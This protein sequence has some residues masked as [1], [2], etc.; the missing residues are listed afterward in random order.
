MRQAPLASIA[1]LVGMTACIPEL[2]PREEA[3]QL[4]LTQL[5]ISE[6]RIGS[7]RVNEKA[8]VSLDSIG[9]FHDYRYQFVFEGP[10]PISVAVSERKAAD[11]NGESVLLGRVLLSPE[12]TRRL[13]LLIA[14]YRLRRDGAC[15]TTDKVQ[16]EWS[17][18]GEAP[19]REGFRDETCEAEFN[20]GLI[21]FNDLARRARGSPDT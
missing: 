1:V 18:D 14:F 15:T 21:S 13:D 16:V 4:D 8:T 11:P 12:D 5:H 17:Q 19:R 2:V 7:L 10:S 20:D 6:P 9:C 3:Q